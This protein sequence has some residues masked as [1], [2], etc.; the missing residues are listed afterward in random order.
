MAVQLQRLRTFAPR[1]HFVTTYERIEGKSRCCREREFVALAAQR[2]VGYEDVGKDND[3]E[4]RRNR[5]TEEDL[6]L[7]DEVVSQDA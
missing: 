5:Q 3:D 4:G 1:R 6:S 7:R 2:D